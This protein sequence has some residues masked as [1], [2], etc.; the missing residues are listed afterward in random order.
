M[1][2]TF[3]TT[4]DK[5]AYSVW[6]ANYRHVGR[7][8]FST[9]YGQD[10]SGDYVAQ[11]LGSAAQPWLSAHLGTLSIITNIL[12]SVGVN[13]DINITPSGTG[14]TVITCNGE[15]LTFKI[16][17]IGDWNMDTTGT[18]TVVHGVTDFKDIR[19]VDII[20]RNDA[21]TTRLKLETVNTSTSLIDG[22]ID[23]FD[24]TNLYLNR[25]TAGAFDN[26][27]FSTTSYNRGFI[28]IWT[29]S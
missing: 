16:I 20:I 27:T 5:P 4:G 12:A 3:F 29:T 8:G 25:R 6:N 15:T 9:F 7:C 18:L 19:Q 23:S 1:A 10:S 17:D 26:A 28:V 2:L 11:P 21:D 13:A 24:A 14:N 22:G